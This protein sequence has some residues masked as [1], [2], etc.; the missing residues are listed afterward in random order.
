MGNLTGYYIDNGGD[1]HCKFN[2]EIRICQ[3]KD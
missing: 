3:V 2:T 1:P